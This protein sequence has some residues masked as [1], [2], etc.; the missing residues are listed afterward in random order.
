MALASWAFVTLRLPGSA[1]AGQDPAGPP[2]CAALN[3][4]PEIILALAQPDLGKREHCPAVPRAATVRIRLAQLNC[5][6]AGP[7]GPLP[8]STTVNKL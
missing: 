4:I 1:H 5:Y 7:A 2:I 3:Q 6:G 8:H